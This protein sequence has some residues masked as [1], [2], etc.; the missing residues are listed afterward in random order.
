[1]TSF[2]NKGRF[3][4]I[5]RRIPVYVILNKKAALLGTAYYGLGL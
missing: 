5:L 4:E 2:S 3:A 1:M